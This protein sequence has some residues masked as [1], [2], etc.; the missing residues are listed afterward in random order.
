MSDNGKIIGDILAESKS[1]LPMRSI[2]PE[3]M[4]K[5][6]EKIKAQK[7]MTF[8]ERMADELSMHK[9]FAESSKGMFKEHH[10][11]RVKEINEV[12]HSKSPE[13][14]LAYA[15]NVASY[16]LDGRLGSVQSIGSLKIDPKDMTPAQR[17][18]LQEAQKII[19]AE[20]K[21]LLTMDGARSPGVFEAEVNRETRMVGNALLK[22][23]VNADSNW[24]GLE[25]DGNRRVDAREAVV[26]LTPYVS[27]SVVASRE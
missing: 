25:G 8:R 15:L 24:N 27:K 13:E 22:I 4:Q 2:S 18:E 1:K 23:G 20:Y 5:A 6:L 10:E 17:K 21:Q 12:M 3:D 14:K 9:E 16:Y 19:D 7:K 11:E 26:A